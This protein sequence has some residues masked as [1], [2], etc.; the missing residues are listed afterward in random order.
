MKPDQIRQSYRER[1]QEIDKRLEDFQELKS[2]SDERK[3]KELAFVIMTSQT[4]ARKAWEAAEKLDELDLLLEGDEEEIEGVLRSL[5][6]SYERKKASF[7]I[8]NR[9]KLSQPSLQDPSGGLKI[10]QR[11]KL[12]NLEK[13]RQELVEDLRG[14]GMKGASH[15]LRNIGY[16]N[17]FAILSGH[18]MRVLHELGVVETA[19]PPGSV[20]DY[21]M[22][23][24]KVQNLS[25]NLEIDVKALDLVLWSMKTGEV[26]K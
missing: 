8:D 13:T 17:G 3:F 19:S 21:L 15:F 26:F 4:E 2:G 16:G 18:I 25:E 23:E 1:K 9:R 11:I 14:V 5:E 6:I 24:E 22:I 7:V 12:D 10:E 20:E